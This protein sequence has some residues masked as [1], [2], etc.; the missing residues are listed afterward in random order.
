MTDLTNNLMD[1]VSSEFLTLESG[2]SYQVTRIKD[3]KHRTAPFYG[4]G[5]KGTTK[6]YDLITKQNIYTEGIDV[7]N[8]FLQLNPTALALFWRLVSVRDTKTNIVNLA[9]NKLSDSDKNRLKKFLSELLDSQ[10]VCRIKRNYLLINPKAIIPD[11]T[12]YESVELRWNQLNISSQSNSVTHSQPTSD[13]YIA[14]SRK[15]MKLTLCTSGM[16][17]S[18]I[19]IDDKE[20]EELQLTL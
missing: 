10:L 17:T 2:D 6:Y 1:T 20:E 11:Y 7:V 9:Q 13:E 15:A 16:M 19:E 8:V 14:S 12:F 4:I 3:R 5:K 18:P